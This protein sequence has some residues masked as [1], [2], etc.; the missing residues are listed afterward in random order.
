[1]PVVKVRLANVALVARH[2]SAL[3]SDV[4]AQGISVLVPFTACLARPRLVI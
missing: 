4:P 2:L 3:V 1:V